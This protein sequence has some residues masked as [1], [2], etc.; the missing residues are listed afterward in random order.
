MIKNISFNLVNKK[1]I[2][3]LNQNIVLTKM[4]RTSAF[5]SNV[6]WSHCYIGSIEVRSLR[7][8]LYVDN[9]SRQI[10]SYCQILCLKNCNSASIDGGPQSTSKCLV[11]IRVYKGLQTNKTLNHAFYSWY[12]F[13]LCSMDI[14]VYFLMKIES[15]PN[16]DICMEENETN[17]SS[18]EITNI[19]QQWKHK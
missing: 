4:G 19:Y 1:T 8:E 18:W 15:N 6:M 7:E 2:T 5:M 16:N 9:T 11:N 14:F 13:Q 10:H 12:L 3:L 17:S